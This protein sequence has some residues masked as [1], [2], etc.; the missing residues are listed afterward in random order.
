MLDWEVGA[1]PRGSE[2]GLERVNEQRN[3]LHTSHA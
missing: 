3:F 1:M 2:K